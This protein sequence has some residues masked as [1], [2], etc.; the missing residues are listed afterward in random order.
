MQRAIPKHCVPL[1]IAYGEKEHDGRGG[2]RYLMTHDALDS[3]ERVVGHTAK[4][5]LIYP[6]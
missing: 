2:I 6:G 3:I 4:E 1:L 5:T